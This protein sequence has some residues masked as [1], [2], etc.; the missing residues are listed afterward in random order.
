MTLYQNKFLSRLDETSISTEGK[1][2]LHTHSYLYGH[3]WNP[4]N[5][6]DWGAVDQF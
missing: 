6:Y 1:K 3:V 5:Y 4:H 2:P